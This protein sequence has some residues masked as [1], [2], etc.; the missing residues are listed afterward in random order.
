MDFETIL[1]DKAEIQ[2]RI[3]K[4][5]ISETILWRHYYSIFKGLEKAILKDILKYWAMP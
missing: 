3:F 1:W 2:A 5:L 4:Q